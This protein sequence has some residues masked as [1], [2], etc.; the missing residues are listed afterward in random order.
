MVEEFILGG[1]KY[2]ATLAFKTSVD[3]KDKCG[4]T[5]AL[6]YKERIPRSVLMEYYTKIGMLDELRD[7]LND[8]S[9]EY[10]FHSDT[11]IIAATLAALN[12]ESVEALITITSSED[13][14]IIDEIIGIR[15]HIQSILGFVAYAKLP[16]HLKTML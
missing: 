3:A 4:Y 12:N 7:L 2:D 5:A 10:T 13:Y 15:S 16:I 1:L 6:L 8:V 14:K 9:G 11:P